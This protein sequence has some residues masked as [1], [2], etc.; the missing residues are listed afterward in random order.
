[1]TEPSIPRDTR[2]EMV[3]APMLPLAVCSARLYK[4]S[5]SLEKSGGD[6]NIGLSRAYGWV[7]ARGWYLAGAIKQTPPKHLLDYEVVIDDVLDMRTSQSVEA[8]T[9]AAEAVAAIAMAEL[10]WLGVAAGAEGDKRKAKQLMKK[11]PKAMLGRRARKAMLV[12]VELTKTEP[13]T[14]DVYRRMSGDLFM[15][16]KPLFRAFFAMQKM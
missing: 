6:E 16:T 7:A 15:A 9:Q 10:N 14:K 3:A 13:N 4:R 5:K 12:M 11:I 8:A 1:M 2:A